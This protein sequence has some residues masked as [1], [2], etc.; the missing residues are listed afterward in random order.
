MSCPTVP[1]HNRHFNSPNENLRRGYNGIAWPCFE[2][3]ILASY[4]LI[5]EAVL[6][7]SLGPSE[8]QK[9]TALSI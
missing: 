7:V 2:I 5:Q 4:M 8:T 9:I 3:N 6:C 1:N